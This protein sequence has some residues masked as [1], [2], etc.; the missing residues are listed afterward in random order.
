MIGIYKITYLKD[1]RSYIGQSINIEHRLR[2][3]Q[4]C[5]GASHIHSAIKKYGLENFSF[6]VLEECSAEELDDKEIKW[7]SIYNSFKNGFNE[8]PGG[9]FVHNTKKI[10][11]FNL[12]GDRICT[13]NSISEAAMST[14]IDA[15]DIGQCVN[16]KRRKAGQYQWLEHD[17]RN[18]FIDIVRPINDSRHHPV[19]QCTLD[20]QDLNNFNSISEAAREIYNTDNGSLRRRI[21]KACD[22]GNGIAD[23]YRWHYHKRSEV[24]QLAD[25]L[26]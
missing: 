23:G 14:G 6:Q 10:D 15:T 18:E 2:E 13:Y 21:K 19:S 25:L 9:Q 7:V 17:P 3:H 22:E 16:K 11:C 24:A 12:Y 8:T 5:E 4:R 20:G 26:D 1:G